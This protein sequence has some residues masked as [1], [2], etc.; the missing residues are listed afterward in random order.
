MPR[1]EGME[2]RDLLAKNGNIFRV[3]GESLDR[4]AKKSV[5]VLVVG[6]PA[7]TNALIC[8]K[9]APTIPDSQFTCLTQLDE[10]RA[11]AILATKLQVLVHQ[12][13]N[14]IIWGNHSSTQVC[15]ILFF[16]N[17]GIQK[18]ITN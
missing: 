1:R 17:K 15:G 18:I 3:Q 9:S 6:N 13:K 5:K 11:R 7:N 4:V 12:I 2:R 10:N 16:F 14:V 8:C